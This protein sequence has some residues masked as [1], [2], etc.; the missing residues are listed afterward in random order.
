MTLTSKPH[1]TQRGFTLVEV[2]VV[3]VVIGILAT[4]AVPV[5]DGMRERAVLAAVKADLRN[6]AAFEKAYAQEHDTYGDAAQVSAFTGPTVL[7]AGNKVEVVAG[8]GELRGFCVMVMHETTR[9]VWFYDSEDGGIM[10]PGESCVPCQGSGGGGGGGGGTDYCPGSNGDGHY[11]GCGSGTVCTNPP[12]AGQSG[13]ALD[14]TQ[15]PSDGS[16][17]NGNGGP[18]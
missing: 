16:N 15:D 14:P 6:F 3:T 1:A 11:V 10:A 13:G 17:G 4:I 2:L 12:R 18:H 9:L 7:T 5:L 8:A